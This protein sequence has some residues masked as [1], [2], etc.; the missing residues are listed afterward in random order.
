M[1]RLGRLSS[2]P[3]HKTHT[4]AN[5]SPAT[6]RY[7]H[8]LQVLLSSIASGG[9]IKSIRWTNSHGG[10]SAA[11]RG[12][13]WKSSPSASLWMEGDFLGQ[14]RGQRGGGCKRPHCASSARRRAPPSTLSYR[15][16]GRAQT[17]GMRVSAP[18]WCGPLFLQR[19]QAVGSPR[20]GRHRNLPLLD[21]GRLNIIGT[22]VSHRRRDDRAVASGR[23]VQACAVMIEPGAPRRVVV[24]RMRRSE[25]SARFRFLICAHSKCL[26]SSC[27]HTQKGPYQGKGG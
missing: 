14:G 7:W 17:A 19:G 10:E 6:R 25:A 12:L 5:G 8:A 3:K 23:A 15:V 27:A 20:H 18:L 24:I 16:I 13:I 21:F 26:A 1:W 11:N 22:A 4:R 9:R 2:G